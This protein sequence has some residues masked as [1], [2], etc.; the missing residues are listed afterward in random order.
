MKKVYLSCLVL[1]GLLLWNS[2]TF[3]QTTIAID[4][5]KA[6]LQWQWTQGVGS[7]AD[8]FSIKCGPTA[9][10]YIRITNIAP[11][12]L[13]ETAIATVIGGPGTYFCTISAY[14]EF[15]ESGLSNEVTF[16]AGTVPDKPNPLV[17]ISN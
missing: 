14:N 12:V 7:P 9:G 10:S 13:R 5:N 8:G 11:G 3:A 4:I 17:I 2:P 6:K 1:L 15:G 16:R